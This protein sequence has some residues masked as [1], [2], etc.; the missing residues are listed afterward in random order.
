MEQNDKRIGRNIKAIRNANKKDYYEFAT[1]INISESLLQKIEN[2][3]KPATDEVIQLVSKISGFSFSTIKFKDLSYLEKGD[4]YFEE[5][6]SVSAFTEMCEF[7]DIFLTVLKVQFPIVE[8][9]KSLENEEFN[10]GIKIAHEKIQTGIFSPTECLAAINHFIRS[11]NNQYCSDFSAINILSCFGYLYNAEVLSLISDDKITTLLNKRVTS[12]SDYLGALKNSLNQKKTR[13]AKIE[14]LKKYNGFLTTY[15]RKLVES[16]E[17][18]DYAYYFL[19]IRYIIGLMD[20]E[21][22]MLDEHQM[23]IFGESMFDC[24]WKMG[25]QYAIKLNDYVNK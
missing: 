18:A 24:L 21:I 3:S 11:Y 20:E 1:A 19:C 2:G 13:A 6:I 14:F 5:D 7:Q 16:K 9:E 4:F 17:N 23:K 22:I 15:M 10:A 25:N 12:M 8:D